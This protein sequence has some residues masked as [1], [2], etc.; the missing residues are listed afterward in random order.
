MTSF[1]RYARRNQTPVIFVLVPQRHL[2]IFFGVVDQLRLFE[3]MFYSG[4]LKIL[5]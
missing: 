3:I 4:R 1:S 2:H 5:I